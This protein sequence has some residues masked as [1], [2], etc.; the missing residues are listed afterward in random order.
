MIPCDVKDH[1]NRVCVYI[2]IERER[3]HNTNTHHYVDRSRARGHDA[4]A[5]VAAL[6]VLYYNTNRIIV[7]L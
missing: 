4:G 3:Y 1:N 5:Q 6:Q 2:Y 7:L